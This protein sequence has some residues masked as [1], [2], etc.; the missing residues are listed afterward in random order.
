[1]EPTSSP[2]SSEPSPWSRSPAALAAWLTVST[3]LVLLAFA[4]QSGSGAD[5][6][7]IPV[8]FRYDF[9]IGGAIV[10]AMLFALAWGAARLGFREGAGEAIGFRRFPRRY[11]WLGLGVTLGAFIVSA[12][13]EPLLHA[14]EEQ[15]L[16]PDE[17]ING[18]WPAF[19]LNALV[20]VLVAPF[21]EE[22]FYRGLGVR[23]LGFLGPVVAIGGTALVF[24]LAHGILEGIP[25]LG[26][27]AVGL[28]WLR[29][30]SESVWPGVIAHGAYNLAGVIGAILILLD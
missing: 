19:V 2:T 25:A 20:V 23:V 27:F 14:G 12:A 24:A 4:G 30:R 7:G 21:V 22:V 6:D 9:A 10:Y 26:I 18:R 17:W 8:F 5:D 13:L 11:V 15:G 29:W 1:M 16:A 3:L 28:G